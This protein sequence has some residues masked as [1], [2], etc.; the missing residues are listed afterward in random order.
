MDDADPLLL[1]E[2]DA[3]RLPPMTTPARDA[4]AAVAATPPPC[5]NV[6]GAVEAVTTPNARRPDGGVAPPT[7]TRNALVRPP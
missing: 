3:N 1:A 4:D 6:V 5:V 7:T 2:D